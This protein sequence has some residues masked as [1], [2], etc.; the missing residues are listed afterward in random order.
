MISTPV[1]DDMRIFFDSMGREIKARK[2]QGHGRIYKKYAANCY[3]QCS[4]DEPCCNTKGNSKHDNLQSV[5]MH[6][7]FY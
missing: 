3:N 5:L 6:I 2:Y 4:L 1:S 7:G